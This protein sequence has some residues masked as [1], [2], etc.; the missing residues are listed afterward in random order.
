MIA[1]LH[2]SGTTTHSEEVMK[3]CCSAPGKVLI[4][5]GYL[6]LEKQNKG[7]VISTTARFYSTIQE[8]P[9]CTPN[10]NS[11]KIL[12]ESPQFNS[13]YD[14][15]IAQKNKTLTLTSSS[16]IPIYIRL[17]LYLGIGIARI[18]IADESKFNNS[19]FTLTLQADNDFYSQQQLVRIIYY[20]Y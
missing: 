13:S 15:E 8:M 17:C 4:V 7:I 11:R 10:T 9:D 18:R 12:I 14:V 2:I 6:I 20:N 19:S 3:V 5:G 16:T 1:S